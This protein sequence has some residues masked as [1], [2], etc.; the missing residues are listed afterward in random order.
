VT[1]KRIGVAGG[2]GEMGGLVRAI[3]AARGHE[4]VSLSR[5]DGV[6]LMTGTGAVDALTGVDTVVDVLNGPDTGTSEGARTFFGTTTDTLLAA[7]KAAGVG[8]HVA[9]SIVGIDEAPY[10]HYAGK[11]LQEE[12]ITGGDV[13][14]TIQRSTQWHSFPRYIYPR[15]KMGPVRVAPRA[16]LQPVDPSEVADRLV[17]AVERG[18][19]GRATDFGGPEE[20][21][22][23]DMVRTYARAIGDRGWMPTVS[24]PGPFGRAQRSGVLLAGPGAD[25]GTRTYAEWIAA[26]VAR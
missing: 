17:D 5:R 4:V 6:D 7:E 9:M 12:L 14:W 1:A 18:P 16:R 25:I 22:L 19:A 23:A 20:L 24:Q 15:L 11:L 8:H 2:T 13:P 21:N 26:V 3:A 10:D